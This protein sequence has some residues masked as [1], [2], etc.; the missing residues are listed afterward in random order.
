MFSTITDTTPPTVTIRTPKKGY[1]YIN[2]SQ[3]KI[4]LRIPIFITT[5]VIGLIDVYANASDNQSGVDRVEF[6]IDN[7]LKT[8]DYTPPYTWR[9][10]EQGYLFP[11]ILTVTAYDNGGNPSTATLRVWKVR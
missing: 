4:Q 3:G 8:V 11:Y 5:L 10:S 2:V 7:A 1:L 6:Y 9:W